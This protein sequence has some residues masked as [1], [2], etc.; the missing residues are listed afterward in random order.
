MFIYSTQWSW[1]SDVSAW[2]KYF[3][4]Y[5]SQDVRYFGTWLDQV[6]EYAQSHDSINVTDL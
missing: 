4:L 6:K 3:G 5:E 1:Q 2:N